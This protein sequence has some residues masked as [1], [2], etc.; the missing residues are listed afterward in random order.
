MT[1]DDV[2]LAAVLRR[3]LTDRSN[4]QPYVSLNYDYGVGSVN[5]LCID[6]YL[7]VS[8][9]EAEAIHRIQR[10]ADDPQEPA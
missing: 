4:D 5:S 10:S 3:F 2:L 1:N 6:G 8:V 7:D 9:E